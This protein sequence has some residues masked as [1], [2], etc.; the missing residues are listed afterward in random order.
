M[1]MTK[2]LLFNSWIII[3]N[4]IVLKLLGEAKLFAGDSV[5]EKVRRWQN[6]RKRRKALK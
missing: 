2:I 1:M 6:Q 4:A 3:P 5:E